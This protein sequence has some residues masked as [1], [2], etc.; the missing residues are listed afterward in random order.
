MSGLTFKP[1]LA[2]KV[3]GGDKTVTRRAVKTNPRSPWF[4]GRETWPESW[5]VCPGRGKNA[6]GYV[7]VV[8]ARK[9]RLGDVFGETLEGPFQ[10]AM[11]VDG[12]LIG[13]AP[14]AAR[15][16]FA[17]VP[18]FQAAWVEINGT[19]DPDAKVWRI[20]MQVIT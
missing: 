4:E 3:M 6:I 17:S 18:E 16:G 15:E 11:I 1:L 7:R 2:A 5:A 12:Q 10:P 8:S 13:A 9:E 14:E 20:E 19:W